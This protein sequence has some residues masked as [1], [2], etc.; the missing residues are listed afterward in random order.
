MRN[1]MK[2]LPILA[3]FISIYVAKHMFPEGV[4]KTNI[5]LLLVILVA[6]IIYILYYIISEGHW[7]EILGG[8]LIS[9]LLSVGTAVFPPIGILLIIWL[10]ISI[11][12]AIASLIQLLP[13]AL[14]SV[15]LYGALLSDLW[16]GY[17][18]IN[19]VSPFPDHTFQLDHMV[20]DIQ[21]SFLSRGA[22]TV[23]DLVYSL[24]PW[25]SL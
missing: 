6:S 1:I 5:E 24:S 7:Q 18:S 9:V 12:M 25:F 4:F 22:S 14:I 17:F 8:I 13:L 23:A 16:F 19:Y 20:P 10:V 15:A 2:S 3:I 11:V 21:R